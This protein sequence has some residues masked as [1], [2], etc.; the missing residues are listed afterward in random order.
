MP[1]FAEYMVWIRLNQHLLPADI[2]TSPLEM[3]KLYLCTLKGLNTKTINWRHS[4]SI[5]THLSLIIY[6]LL[7]TKSCLTF[8]NTWWWCA[9]DLYLWVHKTMSEKLCLILFSLCFFGPVLFYMKAFFY[10]LLFRN[11]YT[12]FI[13]FFCLQR[14]WT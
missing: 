9:L 1:Y 5:Y 13:T 7:R 11:Y 12:I 2:S 10:I 3:T 8:L 6:L 4:I 14:L